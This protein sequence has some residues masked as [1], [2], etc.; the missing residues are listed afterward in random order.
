MGLAKGGR[1]NAARLPSTV[2]RVLLALACRTMSHPGSATTTLKPL[3]KRERSKNALEA[4]Q[5]SQKARRALNACRACEDAAITGALARWVLA[6]C[7]GQTTGLFL[8]GF[9]VLDLLIRSIALTA[10]KDNSEGLACEER[11]GKGEEARENVDRG[12]GDRQHGREV[13]FCDAGSRKLLYGVI[14]DL[15]C[16]LFTCRKGRTDEEGSKKRRQH[17]SSVGSFD[18]GE[19]AKSF[20]PP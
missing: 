4:I 9:R 20:P 19:V 13:S 7:G 2:K 5:Q 6:P 10:Q 12:R 1:P 17:A 3:T 15:L 18:V 11:Q 8:A 14:S 16:L